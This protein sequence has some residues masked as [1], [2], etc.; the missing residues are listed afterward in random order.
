M[1]VVLSI[2][3]VF[4]G[5]LG[6]EKKVYVGNIRLVFNIQWKT[7]KINRDNFI[8]LLPFKASVTKLGNGVAGGSFER[9]WSALDILLVG[10]K[11]YG[12]I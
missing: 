8:I 1:S 12:K 10:P 3:L 9:R 11:R 4:A 6:S 2:G 7:K 5:G